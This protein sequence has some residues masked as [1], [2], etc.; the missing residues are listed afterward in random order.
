MATRGYEG[1]TQADVTRRSLKQQKVEKPSKYRNV[2]IV[3][4]GERFDS[5]READAW[6]DLKQQQAGGFI[7]KLRR[8]V[9][10]DLM[11]PK[12]DPND[13]IAV[14]VSQYIADFCF[15]ERWSDGVTETWETITQ[16]VK[17]GQATKTA[18]Y[19]LKK[20]WIFL[21]SAIEIREV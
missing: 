8:Q 21:Q 5:K 3:I 10:F 6:I 1:F 17:G 2:K 7:R 16:D 18:V 14:V 11:A 13:G 15:E 20:K 9:A 4:D 12:G 19:Q